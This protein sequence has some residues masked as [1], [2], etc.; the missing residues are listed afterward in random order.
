M[1]KNGKILI[2]TLT[3]IKNNGNGYP[4]DGVSISSQKMRSAS[5]KYIFI[6]LAF[7]L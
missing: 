4:A 3:K 5:G 7:V 2:P 1:R 6:V